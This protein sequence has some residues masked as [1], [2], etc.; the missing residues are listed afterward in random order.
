MRIERAPGRFRKARGICG[1]EGGRIRIGRLNGADPPEPQLLHQPVLQRQVR[2]FNAPFGQ[3]AVR[4]KRVDVQLVYR[5]D[6]MRHAAPRAV[7]GRAA[8][9]AV[10]VAVEGSGFA[11]TLDVRTRCLEI[12][13]GRFGG[14]EVQHHQLAGRIIDIHQQRAGPPGP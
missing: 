3:A 10:F 6:E 7:R 8:E 1:D 5:P 2:A 14:R 12:A 4:A 11:V 13:E 9:H